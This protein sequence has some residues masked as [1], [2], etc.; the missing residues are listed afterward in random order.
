LETSYLFTYVVPRL[1]QLTLFQIIM[2]GN[3][4][5]CSFCTYRTIYLKFANFSTNCQFLVKDLNNLAIC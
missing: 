2:S 1:L 5:P 4:S 3:S